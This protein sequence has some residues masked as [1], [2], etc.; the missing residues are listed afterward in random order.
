PWRPADQSL[1]GARP[2]L[3]QHVVEL[4]LVVARP[5]AETL[6]DQ[7]AG[8]KKFATWVLASA[9][10]PDGHAPGRHDAP[11]QL[12]AGV[13]VDHGNGGV[14]EAARPQDRALTDAGAASHHA[15]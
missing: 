12:D 2:M 7:H 14:E 8:H 10:G 1:S 9:A 5:F 11:A 6:D 15:A 3:S 13:G 4:C